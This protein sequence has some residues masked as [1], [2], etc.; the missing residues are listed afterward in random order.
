MKPEDKPSYL[1]LAAVGVLIA[2][3]P[4]ITELLLGYGVPIGISNLG[5]VSAVLAILY[6]GTPWLKRILN[7]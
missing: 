6:I 1:A 4:S 5:I 7:P 3:Q 2:A